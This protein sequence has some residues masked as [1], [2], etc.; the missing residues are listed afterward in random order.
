MPKIFTLDHASWSY[1]PLTVAAASKKPQNSPKLKVKYIYLRNG[2]SKNFETE[3]LRSA[4]M[5]FYNICNTK[6]LGL[7]IAISIPLFYLGAFGK[8]SE[9]DR[10]PSRS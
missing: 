7:T 1:D 2:W 6:I 8:I 10:G 5:N 9:S 4:I 3:V